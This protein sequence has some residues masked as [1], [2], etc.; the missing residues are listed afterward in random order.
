M[1]RHNPDTPPPTTVP[2]SPAEIIEAHP[3]PRKCLVVMIQVEPGIDPARVVVSAARF[4]AAV[5]SADR[6][7]RLTVDPIPT[8]SVGGERRAEVIDANLEHVLRW[9]N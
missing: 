6:W 1:N 7:L 5:Q 2:P 8:R 9:G 3:V 4:I